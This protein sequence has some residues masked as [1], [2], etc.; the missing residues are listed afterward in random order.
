MK[1]KKSNVL[2]LK[3]AFVAA[4]CLMQFAFHN[5]VSGQCKPAIKI[6]GNVIVVNS[7]DAF[8]LN[9][10]FWLKETQTLAISSSVASISVIEFTVNGTSLEYS[11]VLSIT[12][13]TPVAVPSGKIWKVESVAK[14]YNSSGYTSITFTLPGSSVWTVPSCAEQICVELWGGGGGGGNYYNSAGGSGGGGGGGAYGQGCYAVTPGSSHTVTVGAGGTICSSCTGA[15]GTGGTSSVG[16][17]IYAYGGNG[18]AG[19]AGGAGGTGGTSTGTTSITGQDGTA[20]SGSGCNNTMGRGGNGANGGAGGGGCQS[21]A[22]GQFPSG[23]GGGNNGW[24]T[25]S[26]GVGGAGKVIITW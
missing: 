17:L 5:S 26:P 4:L 18:G 3:T 11:Q 7:L 23:G 24:I 20:G 13:S 22:T 21:P 2:K 15:G 10:P 12:S 8:G 6:D 25:G 1:N 19:G 16:T 9:F 14:M